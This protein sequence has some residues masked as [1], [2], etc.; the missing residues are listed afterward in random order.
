M[1]SIFDNPTM[2]DLAASPAAQALLEREVRI[3]ITC[4]SCR[5]FNLCKGG[6]AYNALANGNGDIDPL[7]AAWKEIFDDIELRLSAEAE[8][9]ENIT[10][11]AE[12]GLRR[13]GHPL[14]HKGAVAELG[15]QHGHPSQVIRNGRRIVAAVELAKNSDTAQVIHRLVKL[16]IS[17]T[18][19]TAKTSLMKMKNDL[20][21]T[22]SLNKL[23]IHITF[24]CQL[25]CSH[26]YAKAGEDSVT[27][28]MHPDDLSRLILEG[29]QAGFQEIV[30]TGGEPLIHR[31]RQQ[32]LQYLRE[33]R[34]TLK[35]TKLVL[36]TNF[37]MPLAPS[38]MDHIG[39][40]FD[41]VVASIDGPPEMHDA[42]RGTGSFAKLHRNLAAWMSLSGVNRYRD[43]GRSWA[44]LSLA[45]SLK[46]KDARGV[47]G[48]AIRDIADKLG[49]R[50]VKMRP[51]LPLGR[52]RDWN[53]PPTTEVLH[54]NI[55]PWEV[56]E[57]GFYPCA[58]C[59]I[60]QN[61]YVEPDGTAFPCYAY[62]QPHSFLGNVCRDGLP[63]VLESSTFLNLSRRTVDTNRRCRDCEWRYICGGACRAWG[64]EAA[65]H[66][67]DAP[68]LNCDPLR[69]R[70]ESIYQEALAYLGLEAD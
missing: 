13:D 52:A 16:G 18:E 34:S 40:A 37:S 27:D 3:R 59:G 45:A 60:G 14:I 64:G 9:P 24:R 50:H 43:N 21:A 15:R 51:L 10:L 54:M 53:E 20:D 5:H 12:R 2:S 38:D 6:C 63:S 66:D 11:L 31:E 57:Q 8:M 65:Q 49:I 58:S 55:E 1:G 36:R 28:E 23:Y 35:N 30:I 47:V 19:E 61:L 22:G 46:S 69:K 33:L 26:C 32:I 68:P 44:E 41:Q 29:A 48:R 62:H 67:L 25:H 17:R 39:A 56:L 42:R 70:A 7:C 4:G